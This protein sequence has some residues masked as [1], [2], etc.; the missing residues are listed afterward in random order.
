MLEKEEKAIRLLLR[1][2][3]FELSERGKF[4]SQD[5]EKLLRESVKI[6]KHLLVKSR[7]MAEMVRDVPIVIRNLRDLKYAIKCG[8]TDKEILDATDTRKNFDLPLGN[9]LY[10][11]DTIR[12]ELGK[13]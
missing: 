5:N 9:F 12:R 2:A 1:L 13:E 7:K 3:E 6:V 10:T 8:W 4:Y 11:I